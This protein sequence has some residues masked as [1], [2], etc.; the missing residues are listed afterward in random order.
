MN[1]RQT[2]ILFAAAALLLVLVLPG[3]GFNTQVWKAVPCRSELAGCGGE[4]HIVSSRGFE[5][6]DRPLLHVYMEAGAEGF[7]FTFVGELGCAYVPET[8]LSVIVSQDG[9]A[10]ELAG[11]GHG[12][13]IEVRGERDRAVLLNCLMGGERIDFCI[14]GRERVRFSAEPGNFAEVYGAL[15]ADRGK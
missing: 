7:A 2:S 5:V 12:D 8:V 13:R 11:T 9:R 4:L 15:P 3:C 1:K 14:E 6:R 10:W